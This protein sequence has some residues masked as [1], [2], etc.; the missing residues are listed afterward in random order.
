MF[1]ERDGGTVVRD[2]V[3]AARI[4]RLGTLFSDV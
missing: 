2:D 4:R 1:A 3:S